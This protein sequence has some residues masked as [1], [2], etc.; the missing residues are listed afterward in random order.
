MRAEA[1]MILRKFYNHR[2]QERSV[3]PPNHGESPG[4]FHDL[5]EV[6]QALFYGRGFLI[7]GVQPSFVV[8]GPPD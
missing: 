5:S 8:F 7:P 2:G 4:L 1:I 3:L 6:N